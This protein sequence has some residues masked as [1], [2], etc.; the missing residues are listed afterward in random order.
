MNR[1]QYFILLRIICSALLFAVGIIFGFSPIL[2]D[3]SLY[4]YIAAAFVVGFD[5]VIDA[6]NGIFHGHILDENFLMTIGSISAFILGECAEGTVILLLYQVGELF[7]AIAVGKSR[8][9]IS[10]LMNI[11]PDY[12]RTENGE[13][14]DPFEVSV[15]DIILVEPGEKVALDGVIVSGSS[16]VD[17]SALTGE[18]IPRFLNH[19]HTSEPYGSSG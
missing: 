10:D 13:V 9:S 19:A 3:F 18:P 7:Q 12:A 11:C 17:T 16:S 8:N 5:V 2:S 1:K 14:I 15:G 4:M 6:F